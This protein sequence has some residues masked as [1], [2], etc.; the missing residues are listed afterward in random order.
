MFISG[1]MTGSAPKEKHLPKQGL[2]SD[3]QDGRMGFT[4]R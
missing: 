2:I 3:N 1:K 4:S